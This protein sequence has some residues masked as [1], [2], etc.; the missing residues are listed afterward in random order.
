M[1]DAAGAP[2]VIR[3]A[4]LLDDGTPMPTRY[5]LVGDAERRRPSAGS[6]RPAACSAAEADVD[7]DGAGR[8]P[9]AATPPSATPRIPPDHAGPRP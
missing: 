6:R 4:P 1:R 8:R 5:W 7:P 3:N 9:R 2:V